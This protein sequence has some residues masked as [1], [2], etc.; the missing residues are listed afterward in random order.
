MRQECVF[1]EADGCCF[2]CV[3]GFFDGVAVFVFCFFLQ[4]FGEGFVGFVGDDREAVEVVFC[5]TDAVLVYGQAQTS[6][7]FLTLFLVGDGGIERADLEDIG[8]VPSFSEG[9]VGE[10]E[11]QGFFEVEQLFFEFHDQL[12]GAFLF[13]GVSF[14]VFGVSFAVLGEVAVVDFADGMG[15]EI[16][17]FFFGLACCEGF[18]EP[19]GEFA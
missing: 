11:L 2:F 1:V 13:G 17:V 16:G 6:A 14:A 15:D 5:E 12:V 19:A 3:E 9:G 10:D 4:G 7:D 18:F 8:V